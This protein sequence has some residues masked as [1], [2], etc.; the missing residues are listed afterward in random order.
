MCG[1]E[2]YVRMDNRW[3]CKEHYFDL[4]SHET[5]GGLHMPSW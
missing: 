1:Q 2:G 3:L 4:E 5:W